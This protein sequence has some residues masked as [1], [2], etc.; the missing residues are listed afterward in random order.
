MLY[1]VSK[2]K[3]KAFQSAT[4]RLT[5]GLCSSSHLTDHQIK[6][7][8]WPPEHTTAQTGVEVKAGPNPIYC[9]FF[10]GELI[11]QSVFTFSGLYVC[12]MHNVKFK[13]IISFKSPLSLTIVHSACTNLRSVVQ[14]ALK[15]TRWQDFIMQ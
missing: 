8:C 5:D 9:D 11:L 12:K 4:F 3:N 6:L 10:G 1:I 13:F 14:E 2:K 7:A 15:Y